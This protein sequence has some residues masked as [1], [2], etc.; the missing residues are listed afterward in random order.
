MATESGPGRKPGNAAHLAK[1]L[2]SRRDRPWLLPS[3]RKLRHLQGLSL[4]NLTFPNASTLSAST[5]VDDEVLSQTWKSPAKLLAQ[6]QSTKLELSRST[7][8]LTVHPTSAPAKKPLSNGTGDLGKRKPPGLRRRSTLHWTGATPEVRQQKL[9]AV[10]GERMLDSF[11]TLHLLDDDEPIYISEV[12]P[13]AM[14]PNFQFFHLGLCGPKIAR[15]DEVVVKVWAKNEGM[16]EF[17]F[18]LE[19]QLSLRSLQF[20]GKSL[21]HFYHPLP[22]NCVVFH[23]SDGVYTTFTDLA[24]DE[25]AL[26]V[27]L[28]PP[29]A[30]ADDV[31]PTS[32]YDA[33]MRLSTLDDC[34]QDALATRDKI[35]SQIDAIIE[36]NHASFDLE[37]QAAQ[38]HE[39]L[40]ATKRYLAQERKQVKSASSRRAELQA[41]LTARRDAMKQG[42]R[43]KDKA[44]EYLDGATTKLTDSRAMVATNTDALRDQRRR[45]CEDLAAIYPIEPIPHQALSFTIR[46]LALPNSSFRNSDDDTTAA[47]LGHVAHLLHHLSLYLSIPVPYPLTPRASSSSVSDPIS[48]MPDTARLF[49]LYAQGVARFRFDYAVF[50]L[51]KDIE[52][53]MNSV[54]L[55]VLD[56]RHTLP[57]LKYLLYVLSAAGVNG[58]PSPARKVGGVRALS[59]GGGGSATGSALRD[60]SIDSA[61][62]RA[63]G[64]EDSVEAAGKQQGNFRRQGNGTLLPPATMKTTGLRK[65]F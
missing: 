64:S 29:T 49:P 48:I 5:S 50:L 16:K 55:A 57:N 25:P 38:A 8:D 28:A 18:L 37:A 24:P 32:S 6:Q 19:L 43:S 13:K 31:T 21:D 11:F 22:P 61:D 51:N 26:P 30:L 7:T 20:I 12:A 2:T 59:Y 41:S 44:R 34:I 60:S 56:L 33:L 47:A 15:V 52:A 62:E 27:S 23:L 17:Q 14:N 63:A 65:V 53:V 46:G 1:A 45:I 36:Q 42:R 39:S 4:R 35:T 40:A 58:E 9:E 10:L 54:G 3:N